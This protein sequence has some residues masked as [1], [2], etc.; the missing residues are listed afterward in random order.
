MKKQW[1]V[2]LTAVC[3]A[4]GG[5]FI[6]LYLKDDKVAPEIHFTSNEVTYTEGESFDVLLKDVTA[7]DDKDGDVTESLMVESIY[8]NDDG[9]TATVVYVAK[10]KSN[11]VSRDSRKVVYHSGDLETSSSLE[12]NSA[13]TGDEGLEFAGDDYAAG[14]SDGEVLSE[15]SPRITLT[16]NQLTIKAGEMVNRVAMV[17]EIT[18]D[19]DD[20]DSLWK[21]IQIDGDSLDNQTPGTYQLIYYVVDSDGNQ[22]NKAVLNVVVQ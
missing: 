20:R 12:N 9:I 13:E 10:D 3:L 6:F 4:L 17:S 19:K 18:D 16:T 11:N 2:L 7:T 8:P 15:G 1:V 14:L 5:I 21:N 22:S